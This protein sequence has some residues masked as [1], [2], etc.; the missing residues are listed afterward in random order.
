MLNRYSI[1]ALITLPLATIL[2]YLGWLHER[3]RYTSP[4]IFHRPTS[5]PEHVVAAYYVNWAIYDRNYTPAHLKE[6]VSKLSH[7]L[8]AFANVH[9]NGTIVLGDDWADKDKHFD[10]ESSVNELADSWNDEEENLYG[11]L[12]QFY[13]LKQLNRHLKVSLSVGGWSWSGN[14]A[15]VAADPVKRSVFAANALDL[16]ENFGLDGI[17]IDWEFP[18]NA[19]EAQSFAELL[20]EVRHVFDT[21]RS[22]T[23]GTPYLL[24]VAMSCSPETYAL[25]PLG[26]MERYV[27]LF[28]LMAYDLAGSWDAVTGHQSPLY[29]NRQSIDKTVTY[30]TSHGVP[31]QKLVMGMPLYGRGFSA[32]DGLGAPFSGVPKGTWEEGVY[33]YNQLPQPGATEYYDEQNVASWTYDNQTREFVTFDSPRVAKEKCLYIEDRKLGGAMFWELSADLHGND[34]RSLLNTVYN[35]FHQQVN[36]S[37]NILDYPNSQ[38]R[39]IRDR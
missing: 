11:S 32:T 39:N 17:D 9:D 23:G 22:H 18:K 25:L 3:P 26:E 33:D 21:K 36:S 34:E 30:F 19:K 31:S 38:F 4:D 10:A 15:A 2:Y 5:S 8:Y 12:H 24:S 1:Y 37:P 28:Y 7:V 20:K 14:F 27:D 29:G 16:V 6:D 13:L 35:S